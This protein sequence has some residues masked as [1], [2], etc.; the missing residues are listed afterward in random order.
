MA[1]KQTWLNCCTTPV[2]LPNIS[3]LVQRPLGMAH[4]QTGLGY[5]EI[6]EALCAH[7]TA[8]HGWVHRLDEA[9]FDG[10]RESPR[11]GAKRKLGTGKEAQRRYQ[12]II[13]D[14]AEVA[15]QMQVGI[16]QARAFRKE[17][18]DAYYFNWPLKN[19]PNFSGAFQP[20]PQH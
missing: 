18:G 17:H 20:H 19:R 2:Q 8:T 9:G 6:A 11:S 16:S 14:P 15:G 4:P 10:I 7:G 1:K 13:D 12:I 5:A 3:G